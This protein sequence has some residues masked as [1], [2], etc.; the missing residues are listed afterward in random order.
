MTKESFLIVIIVYSLVLT[1]CSALIET[2]EPSPTK[3][4][5]EVPTTTKTSTKTAT[6][7]VDVTPTETPVEIMPTIELINPTPDDDAGEVVRSLSEDGPWW[8]FSTTVDLFGI[9]PDGTGVT[10]FNKEPISQLFAQQTVYSP[11][12]GY[13]A[14]I[15]GEEFQAN[16]VIRQL[17]YLT[18]I[19]EIPLFSYQDDIDME[20]L[21]AITDYQSLAFSPNGRTLAFVGAMDGPTADLYTYSLETYELL[22]VSD[23][24]SQA[25]QPVWSPDGK[26]IV[27]GGARTFGSGAGAEITRVWAAAA[28][29]SDIESMYKPSELGDERIIGWV[30]NETFLVH[31]WDAACGWK[32]L[33]T[34]NIENNLSTV[35]WPESFQAAAYDPINTVALVSSNE[36]DCSPENGVGYYW[37][38]ID[39][40]GPVRV[41]E[42]PDA[43]LIWSADAEKFMAT[44]NFDTGVRVFDRWGQYIDLDMPR[45]ASDFPAVSPGTNDLAWP[46]EALW[47]GPFLGSIDFPPVK[48]FDQPVAAVTWTPDG[49]S[50]IFLAQGK[51]YLASKPD[52]KPILIEENLGAWHGFAGWVAR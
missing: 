27:F 28:D 44:N 51:L 13:V 45:G 47:I 1:G 22:R 19:N 30:D 6:P 46:G 5:F 11:D 25:F 17:P 9:N 20:A 42:F 41:Y 7:T 12:G 4:I 2:P 24:P 33:R 36:G 15:F 16:L 38:P 52:Y 43:Q 3:T 8:V 29:G 35:L 48:I 40:T 50:V 10:P 31:S 32:N 37:I 21:R 49:E 14:F 23:G 34:F 18:L 39:G 26:T